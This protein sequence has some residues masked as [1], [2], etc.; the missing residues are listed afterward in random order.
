MKPAHSAFMI[1]RRL[2]LSVLPALSAVAL[3]GCS[4]TSAPGGVPTTDATLAKSNLA[5]VPSSAVAASALLAATDANNAFAV[6]L[7][8]QVLKAP[9]VSA[10]NVLTS[11]ISASLALTMTMAGANGQTASE[12]A[13]ALHIDPSASDSIYAG[14]NA[15]TQAF[16]ARAAAA[17]ANDSQNPKLDPSADDY[18]LQVVNS[19]WGE[20]TYTWEAPFLDNLAKN[21]GTGVYQEDFVHDFEPARA[22]INS[23]VSDYTKDKIS[24]LLP[25]KSLDTRTRMVLVN[26]LHLKMPWQRKFEENATKVDSFTRGD[27]S[28]VSVDFMTQDED[29]KYADE[30]DAQVIAVPLANRELSVVIAMPHV[31]VSLADYEAKLAVHAGALAVP[32]DSAQIGLSLPKTNFASP[33]FSLGDAL[34]ALG[35]TQAFDVN[36]ADFSG[37]CAHP[38]NGEHLFLED[39]FQKATL[40]MQ[41]GGVEAAA[42]TAAVVSGEGAA[43]PAPQKLKIDRPFVIS[44]VDVPSGAVLMLGHIQDPTESGS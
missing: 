16:D 21:Y 11:P 27:G 40:S 4:G 10:H 8:G 14:Q 19:I 7:Y 24:D 33:S 12:M 36:Q 41:E 1:R 28:V 26:A 23:W 18:Q 20:Q 22:A 32:T 6:D 29:C 9:G 25:E 44:I 35:V 34:K 39:V 17:F 37:L 42:G 5:R 38:P 31:G 15:L 2:L 30:S 13:A 43:A 3:A